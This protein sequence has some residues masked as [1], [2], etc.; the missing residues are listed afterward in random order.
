[1]YLDGGYDEVRRVVMEK[2][3]TMI[4]DLPTAEDLK[5]PKTR[6][7]EWLQGR[8]RALPVYTLEF[9]EGAAHA[10]TFYVSCVLDDA[11]R[12][13]AEGSSRGGAEQSAAESML[14]RLRE[15]EK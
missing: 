12:S 1:M 6:L 11:M 9:E 15:G 14:A 13:E 10:K 8:G 2:F 4:E 5:D 3:A 7:Q